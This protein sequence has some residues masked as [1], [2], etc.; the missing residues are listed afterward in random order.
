[1]HTVLINLAIISNIVTEKK[2]TR[3]VN[4]KHDHTRYLCL[5]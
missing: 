3:A 2:E 4:D 5:A 1:M